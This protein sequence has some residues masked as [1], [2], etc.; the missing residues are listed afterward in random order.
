MNWLKKHWLLILILLVSLF[1]RT[2]RIAST[3]T[4]LEDEGRDLLIAKRMIDTGRPVLLGPQTSMGNMYLGPLYYYFITPALA[5]YQMDPVG[6]AILIALTG[7]ITTYLLFY[8]GRKWF[9][10]AAGYLASIMYAILPFSVSVN[11]SSW[12]PNLVPLISVL[13]LIVYDRIVYAKPKFMDWIYYGLLVGTMVQLHYMALVFCGV[14]SLSIAWHKRKKLFNLAKGVALAL[15]GFII[16]LSPFIIFE[17]RNDWVNTHALTRFLVAKQDR[18]IRY[19]LPAW[20]WWSKVSTTSYRLIGDTLIGSELGGK[21]AA[22]KVVTLFVTILALN[23]ILSLKKNNGRY[24]NLIMLWVSSMAVLGIYQEN[25]HMHYIE[26]A[27]PLVIL[28]LVG[29][30]QDQ[31]SHFTKLITTIFIGYVLFVGASRSYGYINSGPTHQAEKAKIITSHIANKAGSRPY[32]I[33]SS[34]KT[35]TSPYQYFAFINQ[36]PPSNTAQKLVYMIC[37]DQECNPSDLQNPSMFVQGPS[38]PTLDNYIG[39]P[40]ATYVVEKKNV[41]SNDHVFLGIWVAEI[42]LE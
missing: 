26:F 1:F 32:N 34:P 24:L 39:H 15:V 9:S 4:F 29:V 8:L 33:V 22:P 28:M 2:Y 21:A 10:D 23:T 38:H 12:N 14:M 31:Y 41:M 37:Q 27:I 18:N 20:L 19:D 42:V 6:P 30:Y 11:R 40:L 35:S 3:M 25:I 16:M 5:L 13:M 17:L 7:V 36:H